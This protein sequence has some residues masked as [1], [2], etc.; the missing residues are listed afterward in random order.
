M[1]NLGINSLQ[2]FPLY[3]GY[4]WVSILI[5]SYCKQKLL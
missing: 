2:S 1:L 5:T 3:L 4:V